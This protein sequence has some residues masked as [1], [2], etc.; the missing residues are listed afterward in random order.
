MTA[1]A[2]LA[3]DPDGPVVRHRV[4]AVLPSL[5]GAGFGDVRV[6]RIPKGV[7]ARIAAFREAGACTN[8]L[9]VRRLFMRFEFAALRAAAPR[10]A[11]DFDDAVSFRDPTR[12]RSV[13]YVRGRRFARSV[14][15]A[16][17]VTAGNEVLADLAR[18]ARAAH[19]VIAPT[20]IDTDRYT[21]APAGA[22]SR[23]GFRVGWIGSRSTRAYLRVV[24][25][26]LRDLVARRADVVVAVMAD[27]APQELAGLPVEFTPWSGDA[28][29]PF[30]RSLDA[31]LMPL[32]DDPWSR[33][34]C[35][36]KLLQYM[37]CGVPAVA[38]PV[39]ANVAIAASGAAARLAASDAE[40]V[41]A[42]DAIAADPASARDLAARGRAAAEGQWSTRVL[43][44]RFA[45]A[46]AAW[47]AGEGTG[48]P[49]RAT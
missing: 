43:G 17:L 22:A 30:L 42:L 44:P 27:Q 14:R 19:V 40:W 46:L 26:P 35:G 49:R 10:L 39:G 34:K 15:G 2:V 29:V 6:V 23:R 4:L 31:G 37:A 3:E 38:S 45:A 12:G 47:A 1:L 33:G 24:A 25:G 7:R 16:D 18:E 28:E 21:P 41:A 20:P 13:S 11:F 32:T 9:L 36:F 48:D 8:V 5:R